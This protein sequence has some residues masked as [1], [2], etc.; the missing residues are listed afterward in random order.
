MAGSN[1]APQEVR[2]R[3]AVGQANVQVGALLARREVAL[4]VHG[5]REHLR[6]VL[7]DEGRPISLLK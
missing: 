7:E 1:S 4:P 3:R 6:P 5:Q 2:V